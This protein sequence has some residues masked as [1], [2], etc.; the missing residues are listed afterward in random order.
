MVMKRDSSLRFE[1]SH[2][3][4]IGVVHYRSLKM[5]NAIPTDA[6][7]KIYYYVCDDLEIEST[8]MSEIQRLR[9]DSI[10]SG[11]EV[12]DIKYRVYRVRIKV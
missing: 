7:R 10:D 11:C 3:S 8:S 4:K 12:S 9:K 1:S 6:S 2:L 5:G